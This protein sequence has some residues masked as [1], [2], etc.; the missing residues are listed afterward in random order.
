LILREAE[1]RYNCH[2]SSDW[3]L[4]ALVGVSK[5]RRHDISDKL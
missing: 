3:F 5:S 4:L 2:N 1:D